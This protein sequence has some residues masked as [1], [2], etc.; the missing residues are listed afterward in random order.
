MHHLNPLEEGKR[1]TGFKDLALLCPT[2]HR[3]AHLRMKR[4]AP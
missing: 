1:R 2:C 3:I 4:D